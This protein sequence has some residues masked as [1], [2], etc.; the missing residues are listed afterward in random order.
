[1][2]FPVRTKQS[3]LD[4]WS[5][6]MQGASMLGLLGAGAAAEIDAAIVCVFAE[7]SSAR[8]AARLDGLPHPVSKVKPKMRMIAFNSSPADIGATILRL[9]RAAIATTSEPRPIEWVIKP[10]LI[11]QKL[12]CGASP[13]IRTRLNNTNITSNR[14]NKH[15]DVND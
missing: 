10:S 1:M 5:S 14:L 6:D 7:T 8:I 2:E 13:M 4:H 15:N 9:C 3:Q 11:T 12:P